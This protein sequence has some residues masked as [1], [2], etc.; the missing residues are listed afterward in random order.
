MKLII[1]IAHYNNIKGLKESLLSI[2]EPFDVDIMLVDDGS[3]DK[4]NINELNNLYK[5]GKIYYELLPEN[6]GVGIA[7]NLGLNKIRE[8]G[9]H[10]L[11]GRLD[12]GDLNRKNK[13][14]IQLDYLKANPDIKL[15]G[16]WADMVDEEGNL[17]FVL[18]HP[19]KYADIKKKMY[20][21]NMF[22][23]PT[24]V[25]YTEILNKVGDYPEKYRRAAQ[26]YAFFFKVIKHYKAE[27]LPEVLL[28]YVIEDKS[29]STQKRRLQVKHRIQIILEN[30]YFGFYPIYG[31]IRNPIFLILSRDTTTFF[32]KFLY[33]K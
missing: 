16:T 1:L 30:F 13:Y 23:N 3:R 8:L 6:K 19:T 28:D 12:C 24:V 7:A 25:F 10:D 32:K 31:L 33:K 2:D 5:N 21:N 9:I 26:D 17:L 29:I 4:P 27:N 18:R 14:K 15:L 22:I 11:I 20:I